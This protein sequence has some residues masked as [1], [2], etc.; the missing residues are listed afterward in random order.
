[1]DLSRRASQAEA[2]I[3]ARI[4]RL[5]RKHRYRPPVRTNGGG[6][7]HSLDAAAQMVLEQA[8]VLYRYWPDVPGQVLFSEDPQF[9]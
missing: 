9:A 7:V 5:L 6:G 1:M 3:R 4:K 2:A 8:R